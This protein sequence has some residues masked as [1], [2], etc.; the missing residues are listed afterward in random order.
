MLLITQSQLLYCLDRDI[1]I[2]VIIMF[3]QPHDVLIWK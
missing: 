3:S 1:V 2:T